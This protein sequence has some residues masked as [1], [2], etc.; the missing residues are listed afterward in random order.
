MKDQKP[1]DSDSFQLSG[2]GE[3][4]FISPRHH[5][6]SQGFAGVTPQKGGPGPDQVDEAGWHKLSDLSR[7]SHRRGT[8]LQLPL[9]AAPA[10]GSVG[11]RT[12]G[13]QG[14]EK[15]WCLNCEPEHGLCES[16]PG[17]AQRVPRRAQDKPPNPASSPGL[18]LPRCHLPHTP[19]LSP[20]QTGVSPTFSGE[21]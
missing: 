18:P 8:A 21:N 14:R 5:S 16:D 19:A 9:H 10:L 6:H 12:G 3:N 2:S 13:E 7:V 4:M 1:W 11:E 15:T 20:R 17:G